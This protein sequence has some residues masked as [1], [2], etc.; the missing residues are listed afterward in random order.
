MK[1]MNVRCLTNNPLVA[2]KGLHFV[3]NINGSPLELFIAVKANIIAGYRLLTHPL[4][5]SLG[6]DINPYKSIILTSQP[7]N[8]D[9]ESLD[10][11]EK[12]IQYATTQSSYRP[13]PRWDELSLKDFQAI[14]A[15]FIKE[16]L[17]TD[18]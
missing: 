14:D 4:T 15:D 16:F 12:A 6:P 13:K 17:K 8:L 2:E 10:L 3:E 1:N 7:G 5:G 9:L 11:I 18:M